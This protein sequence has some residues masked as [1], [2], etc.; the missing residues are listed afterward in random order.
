MSPLQNCS[1]NLNSAQASSS[2][3]YIYLLYAYR[4]ERHPFFSDTDNPFNHFTN[5]R[6]KSSFLLSFL[7]KINL[8]LYECNYVVKI[9]NTKMF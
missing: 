5:L 4:R 3:L 8:N 9:K 1:V 6:N 7:M 2:N